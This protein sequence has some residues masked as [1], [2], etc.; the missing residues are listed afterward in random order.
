[1]VAIG[2][3]NCHTEASLKCIEV[4]TNNNGQQSIRSLAMDSLPLFVPNATPN[5]GRVLRRRS[6]ICAQADGGSEV[7]ART[8][9]RVSRRAVLGAIAAGV[10]GGVLKTAWAGDTTETPFLYPKA[11]EVELSNGARYFD[12]AEGKGEAAVVGST[13]LIHYTSRLGGLY[14]L[15]LDGTRDG[16]G[17]GSPMKYTLGDARAVPGFDAALLGMRPGGVRRVLCP[18]GAAYR[19]P[20]D[21]P[22]VKDFFARRR[23]L[24][25]LNTNRDASIVF[26]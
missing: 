12:L 14:G 8:A 5:T 23:L 2:Y 20:D 24:S 26:E 4:K 19:S 15:R 16:T 21:F 7:D 9:A 22:V 11:K 25:V 3:E 10:S 13:V 17:N 1:M 18:P 6:L